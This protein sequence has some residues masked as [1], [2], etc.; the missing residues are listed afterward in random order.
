MSLRKIALSS[1]LTAIPCFMGS[2]FAGENQQTGNQQ[3]GT[4]QTQQ[5]TVKTLDDLRAQCLSLRA[6]GQI[7]PFTVKIE[8]NGDYSFW[9]EAKS[10]VTLENAG[11]MYTH[12]STKGER[13]ETRDSIFASEVASQTSTCS[14]YIKKEMRAPEG[15]G[16]PVVITDCEDLTAANVEA[17]CRDEVR[18]YCEDQHVEQNDIA[19][20]DCAG[21]AGSQSTCEKDSKSI[22]GMCV[23]HS[24][25]VLNTCSGY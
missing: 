25:E 16:I 22:S 23:L 4:Q 18:D 5:R 10:R 8:C 20:K 12:S 11:S 9:E 24:V 17:R 19:V 6:D 15:L 3:T 14:Q 21:Q 1:I 7:K 2:L 13:F